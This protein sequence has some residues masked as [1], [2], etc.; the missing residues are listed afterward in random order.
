M[1]TVA[2]SGRGDIGGVLARTWAAAGAPVTVAIVAAASPRA[3][4][5]GR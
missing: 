2:V 4:I 5:S 3:P 1:T